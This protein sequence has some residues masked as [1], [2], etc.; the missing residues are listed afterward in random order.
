MPQM[1]PRL[2]QPA[3][4][5]L[6]L[7]GVLALLLAAAGQA[8]GERLPLRVYTNADGLVSDR[9]SRIVRDP[10]GFLWFCTEGGLSRFD[11][12]GFTNY[13]T[14]QGLPVNWVD[15]LLITRDGTY[16]VATEGGL[17][18]FNPDAA[19]GPL[20]TVYRPGPDI[21]NTR[22]RSLYED[23]AG[24][25]WC[26]TWNNLFR[27][28]MVEGEAR[29]HLVDLGTPPDKDNS[30]RN[31]AEDGQGNLWV[32]ADRGLYRISSD[33][34]VTPFT[35]AQ[36]LPGNNIL[37]LLT[38]REG[39]VWA[40]NRAAGLLLIDPD[41]DERRSVVARRY[42]AREGLPCGR[43]TSIFQTSNGRLWV[44]LDCTLSE[45]LP[46]TGIYKNFESAEILHD[47][48]VWCMAE[49]G[50]GN[51]WV[52]TPGGAVRVS[53]TGFITYTEADGLGRR[54]IYLIQ[55]TRAGELVVVSESAQG[56]RL[57]AFDGRRFVAIRRGGALQDRAGEWWVPTEHGL[58]RFPRTDR[59]RDLAGLR[60]RAVYTTRDGLP[61]NIV[62][63]PYEDARGDLWF[64]TGPGGAINLV[65]WE[66]AAGRFQVYPSQDVR[67]SA[68]HAITLYCDDRAG[69]LWVG[70]R[71]DG[72]ARYREG[73]WQFFT[74]AAGLPAGSIR[75]LLLDREGRLWIA[76]RQGGVA[77]VDD[78]AADDPE[79]VKFTTAQGLSSNDTRSLVEDRFGRIYIGT[80]GGLDRLDPATG[81]VKHYTTADGLAN[82]LV[83]VAFCDRQGVL[84]FGSSTGLSS[85]L[86]EPDAP[87][88]PVRALIAGLRVNGITQALSPL[89]VPEIPAF[90]L[91]PG[92]NNISI[93]FLAVSF[94]EPPRYQ[95]KLEGAAGDWSAP[96][97]QRTVDYPSL[98]P[99]TYRF[100]VRAVN[101][102]GAGSAEPAG[103][104]FT[105]LPPLWQRWW[106]V[107]LAA[108]ALSFTA[109]TGYRYRVARLLELERVRTRIATDL[110]DDIGANLTRIALLS[111]VANQQPGNDKVKTLLPSIA[112]IARESVASMND[113]VWAISP[114]HDS[115]VDLTRRMRRHAEEVFALRDIDLDFTAPAADSDLKLSV[116]ARRDLL[117]I[118]KEA[119]NNAARHSL[120]TK[121]EIEFR[122]DHSG[123]HLKVKD[124]GQGFNP[125]VLNSSGQGLRSMRRRAAALG[126][127]LTIDSSAGTTVEFALPL[128]KGIASHL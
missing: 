125:S 32:G 85:M 72:L 50:E 37:G 55:E 104:A 92:Q 71:P 7:A 109:Y 66:R 13:T 8:R 36:G 15:D 18:R 42:A 89:G 106:V 26:G 46:D 122:C 1:H 117:L 19:A 93:D 10:R 51:L 47:L 3:G 83:E 5:G 79:F 65:R 102:D 33:G 30:I 81:S 57:S 91:R 88:L 34:R 121:I 21:L 14:A 77:R 52:G 23:H 44:G 28:E 78:P 59:A 110:H 17:C 98:P 60:P 128:R 101:A 6:R 120:C 12:Y 86:P 95:Y 123:L 96:S 99:G 58:Y 69:N 25:I 76:T 113:I 74:A 2:W 87:R 80:M 82:Q 64:A 97:Q 105:I 48:P 11:G 75:D 31:L 62:Y 111:E 118:F 29:F 126:G 127:T 45:F 67:P 115:L 116:G 84:W 61:D 39:R 38:D 107:L 9:V 16:W 4:M 119:V 103:L 56:A 108:A 41:A 22:A 68:H 20:F 43:I 124:D 40:G 73:R 24:N 27:V 70:Y 114:E 54:N 100:L 63:F 90:E 53:L 35:T 94:R 49:D 112:D